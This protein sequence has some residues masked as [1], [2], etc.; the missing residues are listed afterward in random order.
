MNIVRRANFLTPR[1]SYFDDFLTKDL[2]D[3]S[4]WTD[5][6]SQVPRVN[7]SESEDDFKVEMA[8]P[9]M[10]KSD[11]Q[12][13]LENDMLTIQTAARDPQGRSEDRH[14]VREEFV[15]G[16]FRRSFHLPQSV[17]MDKIQAKYVDGILSLSIPKKEEAKRKPA[18][19]ITI[20]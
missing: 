8:A 17:E 9:G 12:I 2:F 1:S 10:V 18:R 16:P 11:F 6:R 20:S 3:W 4:A 19:T 7:I 5:R 14:Y 15:P 13:E